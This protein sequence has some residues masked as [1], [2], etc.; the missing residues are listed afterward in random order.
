M[1]NKII[2]LLTFFHTKYLVISADY[3]TG[4]F[5]KASDIYGSKY[6]SIAITNI[7][8]AGKDNT[9]IIYHVPKNRVIG[10]RKLHSPAKQWF[11]K[12]IFNKKL[13]TNPIKKLA[14]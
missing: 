6:I 8:V 3:P 14:K 4:I 5:I 10:M 13:P 11:Y 9:A 2:Q 1:K 12:N 7:A